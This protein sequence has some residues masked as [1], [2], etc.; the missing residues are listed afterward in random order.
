MQSLKNI[1][2]RNLST[3]K[4]DGYT[5]T[6]T[7]LS[8]STSN[9]NIIASL[10]T[11]HGITV[12][13]KVSFSQSATVTF[14]NYRIYAR[15]VIEISDSGFTPVEITDVVPWAANAT[16]DIQV[17]VDGGGLVAVSFTI[18][19][20]DT[21]ADVITA[22][23]VGLG[24]AGLAATAYF[25]SVGNLWA[26]G[27]SSAEKGILIRSNL[28]GTGSSIDIQSGP[29][30]DFYTALSAESYNFNTDNADSTGIDF[31][32]A[33]STGF[34]FTLST[35]YNVTG[36]I[37]NGTF[38]TAP[39]GPVVNVVI[40]NTLT[41]SL[42]TNGY[43]TQDAT[44]LSADT[45]NHAMGGAAIV[46]TVTVSNTNDVTYSGTPVTIASITT[47]DVIRKHYIENGNIGIGTNEPQYPVDIQS[48]L[49]YKNN[50]IKKCNFTDAGA[51]SASDDNT[52]GYEQ[53]SIWVDGG[54]IHVCTNASTGAAVWNDVSALFYSKP[55]TGFGNTNNLVMVNTLG[56]LVD[57]TTAK[58]DGGGLLIDKLT[59]NGTSQAGPRFF[60]NEGSI[61]LKRSVTVNVG[62][63]IATVGFTNYGEFTNP[64]NVTGIVPY[65]GVSEFSATDKFVLIKNSSNSNITF[66]HQDGASLAA[67]R[68]ITPGGVDYILPSTNMVMLFYDAIDYRWRIV[69][70]VSQALN[71]TDDLTEGAT[72]LYFT[73]QR[74]RDSVLTGLSVAS[75]SVQAADNVLQA[76]GKLKNAG[77]QNLIS[78]VAAGTITKGQVLRY[79]NNHA[80]PYVRA[81]TP[82]AGLLMT[83]HRG[84][85]QISE[86]LVANFRTNEVYRTTRGQSTAEGAA[87]FSPN[88]YANLPSGSNKGELCEILPGKVL[89]SEAQS[90][91]LV[92]IVTATEL[93]NE[94][95][96]GAVG[97]IVVTYL[98]PGR[99]LI[100]YKD[101]SDSLV[102][103][104]T[105][106]GSTITLQ[107]SSVAIAG[108]SN[109]ARSLVALTPYYVTILYSGTIKLYGIKVS[110]ANLI[111][112]STQLISHSE[113]VSSRQASMVRINRKTIA[114]FIVD[115]LY[116]ATVNDL[117]D[118]ASAVANKNLFSVAMNSV[119]MIKTAENTYV[120]KGTQ[121]GTGYIK[122]FKIYEDGS[123]Y[124][125]TD[126]INID[127]GGDRFVNISKNTVLIAQVGIYWVDPQSL[128]VSTG[129][130][131]P[132]NL[133][134]AEANA[135]ASQ[136]A[137]ARVAGVFTEGSGYKAGWLYGP[138]D[139]GTLR[140]IG[141]SFK[142]RIDMPIIG[143]A[144]SST[145]LMI[146]SGD[147]HGID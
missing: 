37:Y 79:F 113:F 126:Y 133:Y 75:G 145:S 8:A 21:W 135:S 73:E 105:T 129:E 29:V 130:D 83:D 28:L 17:D 119:D 114:Y 7:G 137:Y 40:V 142:D 94:A 96:T 22:V 15:R 123:I 120:A 66:K 139:D 16:Y 11:G 26:G 72:N 132:D 64:G 52:L 5:E 60:V 33:L 35:T 32:L 77:M 4:A 49:W 90:L 20:G 103:V 87:S 80:I 58:Y 48:D 41:P 104:V 31:D 45:A 88:G 136:T 98:S 106:D 71:D 10:P 110:S 107:T 18:N 109:T 69:D 111:T 122:A 61:G 55:T 99:A 124:D 128:I 84:W 57:S 39:F 19:S 76:F 9:N 56:Y 108:T 102:R 43:T 54:T 65:D 47:I 95:V 118:T 101:S 34:T 13:D 121:S 93:D 134:I 62:N 85:F 146:Y 92:D 70:S 51:P 140:P 127:A 112:S 68:I 63:D 115:T 38:T 141:T 27:V 30:N 138:G 116:T 91:R 144:V 89:I 44:D 50:K 117:A 24:T 67:N 46:G 59:I 23:N 81:T 14:I 143:K 12:G 36:P 86:G 100:A 82:D 131:H 97:E 147:K 53:G 74:V 6:L 3:V 2:S 125:P 78:F 25:N 1:F 42:F